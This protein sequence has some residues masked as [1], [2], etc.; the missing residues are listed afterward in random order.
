MNNLK[1]MTLV[2]FG[3]LGMMLPQA[4]AAEWNQSTTLT[5][6]ESVQIPGQVLNAGTYVFKLADLSSDRNIVQVFDKDELHLYATLLTIPDYRLKPTD[7]PV[8]TFEERATGVPEAIKA[9]FYPGESN[10][11]EFVYAGTKAAQ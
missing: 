9:W 2:T 10:G 5:F 8:I 1:I 3:V 6:P 7:H 11:H 4:K